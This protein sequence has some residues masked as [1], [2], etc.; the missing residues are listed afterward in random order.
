MRRFNAI[1]TALLA[2]QLI[3]VAVVFGSRSQAGNADNGPY[4]DLKQ[5]ALTSLQVS[6]NKGS[7]L[8]LK[9]G[10]NGW[11][12]P[13]R[14]DFPADSQHL[15]QLINGLN[16][17]KPALP[18]AVS[19]D[20]RQRFQVAKDHFNRHLV[21]HDAKGVVADLYLGKNAGANRVYARLAGKDAIQAI[22]LP[23]WQASTQAADWLDHNYLNARPAQLTRITLPQATLTR[24]GPQWQVKGLAD[25]KVTDHNKVQALLGHLRT[26]A[27]SHLLGG[28]DSVTLPA[29]ATFS[30]TVMP[31]SNKAVAYRFYQDSQNGKP[32][33][34][35]NRSDSPYVFTVDSARITPLRDAT[36][37]GLSM[38]KPAKKD[39]G[40]DAP[41]KA[42]AT[43]STPAR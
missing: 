17:V 9:Q 11:R 8:T 10:D 18:V 21:F 36:V 3:L 31:K 33:W 40:K 16:G 23:M 26:L 24:Q 39:S 4:L 42:A 27:W 43:P 13:A 22:T 28:T 30:V 6:D 14:D 12:V 38:D 37:A 35:V 5:N 32:R 19:K 15:D 20:A 29:K 7:S 25:G 1:L 34:R 2:L 41:P